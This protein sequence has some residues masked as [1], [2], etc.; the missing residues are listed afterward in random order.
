MS[1]TSAAEAGVAYG[2]VYH[3]FDSKEQMLN[4]L[5]TERWA[6]LVEASQEVRSSDAAPR[7]KLAGVANFI[8]ESY[9]HEPE[10]MKVII[11]EVTRAANSFGGTHLPEIRQA[12]DLSAEIVSDAQEAGEFRDDVD[13]VRR[14]GLLRAIEQPLTGWIFGSIPGADEDYERAKRWSSRPSATGSSLAPSATRRPAR[15]R[16]MWEGLAR[17]QRQDRALHGA[18][19]LA[20]VLLGLILLP[21]WLFG[22]LVGGRVRDFLLALERRGRRPLPAPAERERTMD[23][24]TRD[25]QA[26]PQHLRHSDSAELRRGFADISNFVVAQHREGAVIGDS[27]PGQSRD[28]IVEGADG[29]RIA[30]SIAFQEAGRPSLTVVHGLFT[31]SRFDY[32]PQIGCGP[33]RAGRRRC[34]PGPAQLR[35]DRADQPGA[36]DGRLAGEPRH[37][38]PRALH[39]GARRHQ[40]RRARQL[41]GGSSAHNACDRTTSDRTGRRDPRRSPPAV[42]ELAGRGSPSRCLG[43]IPAIRFTGRSR[44]R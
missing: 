27:Y 19:K 15:P 4:E 16:G 17:T 36:V 31:S 1:P 42:P 20:N 21:L 38:Q 24:L 3:Y 41:A 40:R 44:R 12:Y 26:V 33:S 25:L 39:E 37:P 22:E 5:F 35:D 43:A 28:H 9:R 2:L 11:V 29:E 30:A 13:R 14:D 18:A 34:R 7:D 6:L 32:V 23:V 8:V 10:Q